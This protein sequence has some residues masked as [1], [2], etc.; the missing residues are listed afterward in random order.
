MKSNNVEINYLKEHLNQNAQCSYLV[1]TRSFDLFLAHLPML[2]LP[3]LLKVLTTFLI[4]ISLY[5]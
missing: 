1:A 3:S 2:V 4:Q 5:F